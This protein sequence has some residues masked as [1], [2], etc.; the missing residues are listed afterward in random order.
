MTARGKEHLQNTTKEKHIR[1]EII[2]SVSG[3]VLS[4]KDITTTNTLIPTQCRAMLYAFH[5]FNLECQSH[6]FPGINVL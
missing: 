4:L 6:T 1:K 5:R 2:D 3:K